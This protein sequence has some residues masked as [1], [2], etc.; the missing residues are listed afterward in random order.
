MRCLGVSTDPSWSRCVCLKVCGVRVLLRRQEGL[1]LRRYSV[2]FSGAFWSPQQVA[3]V[4]TGR[5]R[6]E[7]E[8]TFFQ[9][10]DNEDRQISLSRVAVTEGARSSSW[11]G[12]NYVE[13]QKGSPRKTELYPDSPYAST[14]MIIICKIGALK[15]SLWRKISQKVI[16][17]RC[18]N[19]LSQI[20]ICAEYDK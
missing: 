8:V 11:L 16:P 6:Q 20:C 9:S 1:W 13:H 12:G 15:P 5:F 4:W 19:T 18:V 2:L 17:G 10:L 7:D 14:F 3:S